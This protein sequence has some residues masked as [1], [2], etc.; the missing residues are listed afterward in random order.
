MCT[1]NPQS[2]TSHSYGFTLIIKLASTSQVTSSL[3]LSSLPFDTNHD[4]AALEWFEKVEGLPYGYVNFVFGWIDTAMNN[5]PP[6]LTE[7]VIPIAMSLV[8][9]IQ[10]KWSIFYMEGLNK[11][12]NTN[13]SNIEQVFAVLNERN[14]TFS[15]LMTQVEQDSWVYGDGPAM[16]RA[17]VFLSLL[18]SHN[19]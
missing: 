5:Y 13:L 4:S 18:S 6:P 3:S 8:E 15:Q 16:V 1:S 17:S 19:T 9:R 11:R 10:P 2:I 7:E 12:L 14:Q